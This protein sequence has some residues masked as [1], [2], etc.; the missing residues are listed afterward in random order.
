[1]GP[2]LHGSALIKFHDSYSNPELIVKS[3]LLLLQDCSTFERTKKSKRIWN[4][5]ATGKSN[6]IQFPPQEVQ[7]CVRETGLNW[8]C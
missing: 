6:L 2:L 8:N 4:S 3:P 7:I 5:P 1:M